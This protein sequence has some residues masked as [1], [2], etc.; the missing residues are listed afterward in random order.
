MEECGVKENRLINSLFEQFHI[1]N[2][3]KKN[4]TLELGHYCVWLL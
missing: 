2:L 4:E 1:F 3:R